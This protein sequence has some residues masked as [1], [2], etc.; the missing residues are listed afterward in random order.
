MKKNFY[1]DI[2]ETIREPLCVVDSSETILYR[3]PAF[4]QH[5]QIDESTDFHAFSQLPEKYT[6]ISLIRECIRD[7]KSETRV[8]Q[9]GTDA[10][11]KVSV[12]RLAEDPGDADCYIEQILAFPAKASDRPQT[13]QSSL[14]FD[15]LVISDRAMADINQ[16]ISRIAYFD[17]TILIQG[18]NGSCTSYP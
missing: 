9:E 16:T 12:T 7:K 14:S 10:P 6:S 3:N 18:E 8:L 15:E 5:F 2:L 4:D 11:L 13:S 1:K 17:S